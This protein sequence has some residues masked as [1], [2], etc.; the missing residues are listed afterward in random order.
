MDRLGLLMRF[1]EFQPSRKSLSCQ[2]YS[3]A[4]I[5]KA[6]VALMTL[7]KSSYCDIAAHQ[8]DD[9]FADAI[10]EDVPSEPT[11]RQRIEYLANLPGFADIVDDATVEL[12]SGVGDL[13]LV[14]I[15]SGEYLPIDIDVSVLVND[16][17]RKEGV[18][19]TYHRID[20][21]APIFCTVGTRGYQL[22]NELRP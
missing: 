15:G 18:G 6:Q 22:A 1:D 21:Y 14:R 13:G 4:G 5:V 3:N 16:D 10:G 9:L 20:G 12:L 19:F 17:C 8:K 7:G 2:T 11:F